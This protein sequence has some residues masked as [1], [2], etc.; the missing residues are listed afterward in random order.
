[1]NLTEEL[2]QSTGKMTALSSNAADL[3]GGQH[4]ES[5]VIH[6]YCLYKVQVQVGQGSPDKIS[7]PETNRQKV[8]MCLEHLGTVEIFLN[9]TPMA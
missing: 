3:I 2:K 8:G 5:K 7:Y 9:R 4:E 1:M 6:S